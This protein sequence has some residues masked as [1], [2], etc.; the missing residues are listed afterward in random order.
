VIRDTGEASSGKKDF[1]MMYHQ[2]TSGERYM[3]AAYRKQGMTQAE[4]ARQL[5]RHPSTIGR[6]IKRNSTPFDDAYRPSRANEQANGRR[7]RSR[8]NQHFTAPDYARVEKLLCRQWSPEQVS[9]HLRRVG[10][11]RISHET[12]YRHIWRDK[13]AGGLL[14]THLRGARKQRRKR[15]GA[16]D[17]RGRLAGKRPIS[18]R[19]ADVETRQT[20]GHWEI[21]TVMGTG[22]RDCIVTLVERKSGLTLIGKLDSRT[23]ESLNQRT[24]RLI[25]R[26]ATAFNTIT[27]DNGTEFHDYKF[28]EHCTGVTFYFATPHHS[29]ER[30]TNENTNGLIRQYLPKGSSMQHLTQH[31]C[32][33]IAL[34]L[35]SRPRKRLAFKTPLEC[36]NEI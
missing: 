21:D 24:I 10:E 15:Y 14:Y 35:N 30:G 5:G 26:H 36:F 2:I 17:S 11:L 25:A 19:P 18:E 20:P 28:I 6:E 34:Q 1:V 13:Q 9:G 22:S 4:I 12:I 32:N 27:S 31:Q 8:R 29:W 23:K 16:Y 7:S 33:A 3:L